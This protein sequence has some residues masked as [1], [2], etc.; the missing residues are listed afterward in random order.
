MPYLP[1]AFSATYQ[2]TMPLT[3]SLSSLL[4][5]VF[6]TAEERNF[7]FSVGFCVVGFF[8]FA[9]FSHFSGEDAQQHRKQCSQIS[10]SFSKAF[11]V[12]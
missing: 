6:V 11:G 4:P 9:K 7:L 10:S 5:A 12:I 1:S 3:A 2:T 8:I